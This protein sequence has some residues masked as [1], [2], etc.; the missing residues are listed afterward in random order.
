MVE[1]WVKTYCKDTKS[2][3]DTLIIYR[4][5]V[6]ESQIKSVLDAEV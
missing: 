2:T 1:E 6:G 4:D 5:G 3:P